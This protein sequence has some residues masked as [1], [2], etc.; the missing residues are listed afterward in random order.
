LKNAGLQL[1]IDKCEFEAKSTKYLGFIVEAGKGVQMDPDKVKAILEWQAPTSARGMHS[2]L[3][4]ANFYRRFIRD[5][6]DIA[7]PLTTLT[8]KGAPF[9]W[10]DKQAAAFKLL[11]KMFTTALILMQ[12]D[13]DRKTV[14][15]LMHLTG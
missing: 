8:H 15:R 10:G 7:R 4:F 13:P 6:S 14:V 5:F 3:R 11:K 2:F 9:V 1:D 12:F